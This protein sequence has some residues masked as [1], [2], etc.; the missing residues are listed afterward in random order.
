MKYLHIYI[1]TEADQKYKKTTYGKLTDSS[2][3][4][5]PVKCYY[6]DCYT[7]GN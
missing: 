7:I 5:F 6:W 3:K 2:F 1:Y 4:I